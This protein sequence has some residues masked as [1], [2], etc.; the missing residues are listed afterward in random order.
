MI[1]LEGLKGVLKYCM[2]DG[3]YN[4]KNIWFVVVLNREGWVFIIVIGGVDGKIVV[5]GGLLNLVFEG[6]FED[7][8]F[9]FFFDDVFEYI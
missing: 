6:G 8:D 5:F 2:I 4:G 7:F 9:N 1:G 3:C